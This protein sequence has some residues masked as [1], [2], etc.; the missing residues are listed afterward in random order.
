[1]R[2]GDVPH[3]LELEGNTVKSFLLKLSVNIFSISADNE[4]KQLLAT[5]QWAYQSCA[6]MSKCVTYFKYPHLYQ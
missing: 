1:M 6:T 3:N 2:Y 5:V 4:V